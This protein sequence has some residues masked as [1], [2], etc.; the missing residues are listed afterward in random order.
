M[1]LVVVEHRDGVPRRSAAELVTVGRD[2]AA[3]SGLPLAALVVGAEPSAVAEAMAEIVDTVVVVSDPR[4]EPPRAETL[5]RA[6]AHVASDIGAT[7]VLIATSRAASSYGPRVALRLGGAYVEGATAVVVEGE[8]L[9]V[10][11]PT[12]LARFD[13]TVVSRASVTIVGVAAGAATGAVPTG[14]RGTARLVEVPFERDDVRLAVDVAEARGP[15]RIAL[16][17][18][19]VVVCGGRGLGSADDFERHVGALAERLAAA[20]GVTRA[21]VDAGWRT[22]D[23]LVGQTGKAV[24]P[25]LC[26]ALG[27]SG[28]AHFVSGVNR[29]R[30]MVAINTDAD[31]PIFRAADYGIVGDVRVVVPAL[32]DALAE[33][34]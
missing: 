1:I 30:V 3:A 29:A 34:S 6:V 31:A 24:A 20:V 4:L 16:E 7:V 26:V 8:G 17:E 33:A 22:F 21:V 18:A 13:T 23:D 25:T 32:L 2:L 15:R 5:T 28:A 27:V 14:A 10:T 9:V 11:H 12:H 19:D